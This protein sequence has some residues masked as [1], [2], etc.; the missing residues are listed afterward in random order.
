MKLDVLLSSYG[1][2]LLNFM[3]ILPDMKEGVRYLVGHQ[4]HKGDRVREEISS[5]I[6]QREDILYFDLDTIGVT[7]SRNFLIEKSTAALIY[8]CDDDVELEEN[9][10]EIIMNSHKLDAAAVITFIVNN[11][12]GG[13]RSK[14]SRVKDEIKSRGWFSILSVGTIEITV[15][16]KGIGDIRFP[17]DMGAGTKKPIGDEAIFLS[18]FLKKKQKISYHP[19]AICRH[20]EESSGCTE[21]SE[22]M[23][24]SRGL[25]LR[26][27]FSYSSFIIAPF[28][29]LRRKKLFKIDG[30]Y[31]KGC[32]AFFSGIAGRNSF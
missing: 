22:S 23:A 10:S 25:T 27:I 1:E 17:N 24:F 31:F 15:K 6:K 19:Y 20:P 7:Q 21:N 11:E 9:F 4:G 29:F 14:F 12:T 18:C 26:R 32:I 8:F 28:F 3:D 5:L 30:S 2:R 13:V 16:R